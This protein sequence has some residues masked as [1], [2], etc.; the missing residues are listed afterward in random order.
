M[1]SNTVEAEAHDSIHRFIG[2]R[3]E[4]AV[5]MLSELI[6]VPSDNPPG[7][8]QP[9]VDCAAALYENLGFTVER[10]PLPDDLVKSVG[11]ISASNLV[12][13]HRFGPGPT[14]AL[15]AH[16]D[17]VAPGEGWTVDPYGAEI[18]DG[19]IY[20][21]AATASKSDFV[22]YAYALL[23]LKSL[24]QRLSGTVEIHLTYDEE[25]GGELGPKRLL[26]EGITA[27]DYAICTGLTYVIVTAHNGCLHLE[28]EVN[29]KSSHAARPELGNDA[30]EAA[31]HVLTALFRERVHLN[32]ITSNVEGIAH[33][34]LV[35]GLIRGGI[36]TN[37]LPDRVTMRI[38]RRIL[39]EENGFQVTNEL[40]KLVNDSV[41]S[42]PGITCNTRT[43]MLA[44]PLM[45]L[46]GQERLIAAIKGNADR[47][48]DG[49]ISAKG[50]PIYTDARHY[51]AAGVPTVLYGAGPKN[52]SNANAHGP[53]E[54]LKLSDLPL[55]TEIVALACYDLL[56]KGT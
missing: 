24:N 14:I 53:N 32:S 1:Q 30:I 43:I 42:L 50:A 47:L 16:G 29:G 13:R 33:P 49:G 31:N 25:I 2:E 23:A 38:D 39:P 35:V 40:S 19:W 9:H 18:R 5:A 54:R 51:C 4:P 44:D 45:P 26:R 48:I 15:N 27:P 55:A 7:N 52:V 8:C 17:V 34:T 46:P 11:M 36:N 56:T 28:I 6:R 20:G 37:V 41:Q 12:I 22:T 3:R 10:H 21:R